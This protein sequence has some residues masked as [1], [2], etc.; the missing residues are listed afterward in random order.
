MS[1]LLSGA[2]TY[3]L[4][5]ANLGK[6]EWAVIEADE[7]D[8]SFLKLPFTYSI[9]TNLDKE[10]MDYYKNLKT[11]KKSFLSFI[12]KTPSFG[13]SLICLDNSNL[14]FLLYRLKINNYLTYGFDSKSNYQI[15]NVKK[16]QSYI[17]GFGMIMREFYLK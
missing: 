7:S 3:L 9:V 2:A 4:Y 6:G 13:K 17:H 12:E 15:S 14:K 11:L 1:R 5:H 10:H 16:N 8:G